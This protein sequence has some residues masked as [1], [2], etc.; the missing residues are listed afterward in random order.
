MWWLLACAGGAGPGKGDL[1]GLDIVSIEIVPSEVT[2][3]TSASGAGSQDFVVNATLNDGTVYHSF[4]LVSF[5]LS[6]SSAGAM[7]DLT[8]V[9]STTNGG[10]THLTASVQGITATAEVTVIYTEQSR[11]EGV[12]EGAEILMEA[13]AANSDGLEWV[14]PPDGTVLPRNL[15]ELDFM[16]RDEADADLYALSFR[17]SL[18]DVTV[19]TNDPVWY[20]NSEIWGTITATNAGDSVELRLRAA[21]VVMDGSTVTAVE[22]VREIGPFLLEVRRFDATGSIYYWSTTGNGIV[23][24]SVDDTSPEEWFSPGNGT[25]EHCLGCH[26]LTSDGSMLAYSWSDDSAATFRAGLATV[27]ADASGVTPLLPEDGTARVGWYNTFDPTGTW[28]ISADQTT[29]NVYNAQ[30]G[31][32]LSSTTAGN[33]Y[34]MPDWSPAGDEIAVVSGNYREL[35]ILTH[36]GGG[37]LEETSM[38]VQAGDQQSIYYPTFSPDGKWIAF[39]LADGSF[40]DNETAALYLVSLSGGPVIE[41]AKANQG[42]DLANSWARWGPMPDDDVLWLAFASRRDYGTQ[43]HTGESQIWITA[44]DTDLAELGEDPSRPAFRMVQQDMD[45]SNHTPWWSSI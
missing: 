4:P 20:S 35:R 11:A 10:R 43:P 41:L 45:T 44:I 27:A 28:W 19:Y 6:N 37:V 12:P 5:E 16:W 15:P 39:N 34:T 17:S 23:R 25:A 40:Y 24:T 3:T 18:T 30:T 36:R 1:S 7:E 8:F 26:V 21:D 31:E 22:N 13:A 14:Y 32:Y 38:L 33:G 42:P 2:L 9:A 29:L